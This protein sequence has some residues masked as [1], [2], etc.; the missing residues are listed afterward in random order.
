MGMHHMAA[1]TAKR[2]DALRI[3]RALLEGGV[4]AA[5]GRRRL[6]LVIWLAPRERAPDADSHAKSAR[7]ALT[8]CGALV[9]DSPRWLDGRDTE[10][11]RAA[12]AATVIILEDI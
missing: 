5:L 9:D 7:D 2:A 3:A 11:V 1:H 4:T 10:Y 6:R 8:R 12:H